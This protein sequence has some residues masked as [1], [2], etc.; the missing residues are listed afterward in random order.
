MNLSKFGLLL[1]FFRD[2]RSLSVGITEDSAS[3]RLTTEGSAE[4]LAEGTFGRSL[5]ST[6]SITSCAT[7]QRRGVRSLQDISSSSYLTRTPSM[8]FS[9]TSQR[10]APRQ[11]K[12]RCPS[13][14][15]TWQFSRR[16][17]VEADI[18]PLSL[19]RIHE[20]LTLSDDRQILFNSKL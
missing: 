1:R 14:D 19:D 4:G 16:R 6:L 20:S 15:R 10:G 13:D 5:Y 3:V 11:P 2:R 7:R 12:K 18:V 8:S 17:M 9:S